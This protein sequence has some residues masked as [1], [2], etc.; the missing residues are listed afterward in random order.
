[1]DIAI[2]LLLSVTHGPGN[3]HMAKHLEVPNYIQEQL[4]SVGGS[5]SETLRFIN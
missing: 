2:L 1:M 4:L 5:L 3:S